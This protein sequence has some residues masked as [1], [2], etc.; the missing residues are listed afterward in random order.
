MLSTLREDEINAETFAADVQRL[1]ELA[2]LAE[3]QEDELDNGEPGKTN[4]FMHVSH[5]VATS[6]VQNP[7][8]YLLQQ[9]MT[10]L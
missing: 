3:G 2:E 1:T 9:M 4:H 10:S 8:P 7:L 6:L 5:F